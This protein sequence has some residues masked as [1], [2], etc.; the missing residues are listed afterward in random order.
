LVVGILY[1][2]RAIVSFFICINA[3]KSVYPLDP[4]IW[5]SLVFILT[6]LLCSFLIG[7]SR[8][9]QE[10]KNIEKF[11]FDSF[12]INNNQNVNRIEEEEWMNL[13]D[14]LLEK[15]ENLFNE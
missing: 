13:N 7:Y 12:D 10:Y 1:L 14:P 3:F 9:R 15:K 2:I 5:D 4:N 11:N 8:H 6:E